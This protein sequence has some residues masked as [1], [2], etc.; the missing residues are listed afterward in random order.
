MIPRVTSKL[1]E[2]ISCDFTLN[3]VFTI[4]TLSVIFHIYIVIKP[5]L[6][7]PLYFLM[8]NKKPIFKEI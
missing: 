8:I 4:F 6:V 3:K 1:R 5:Q 2:F 7:H